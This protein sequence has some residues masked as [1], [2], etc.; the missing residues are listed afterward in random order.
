VNVFQLLCTFLLSIAI[1]VYPMQ[2]HTVDS[3]KAKKVV[4]GGRL[5]Q[6]SIALVLLARDP[7]LAYLSIACRSLPL[8]PRGTGIP[9]IGDTFSHISSGPRVAG[10]PHHD[11]LG[12]I[13]RSKSRPSSIDWTLTMHAASTICSRSQL[14]LTATVSAQ[15]TS[16][17]CLY[18]DVVSGGAGCAH[19]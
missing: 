1:Y 11:K 16:C 12:S 15:S 3:K 6:L 5:A 4:P 8:P 13:Y 19:W 14:L 7:R 2:V 17:V 18:Q 10:Q 9:Y